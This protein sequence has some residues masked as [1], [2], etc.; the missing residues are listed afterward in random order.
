VCRSK[1]VHSQTTTVRLLSFV[2]HS[3]SWLTVVKVRLVVK[4]SLTHC[5]L[6]DSGQG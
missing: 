3:A 6:A 5:Q 4:V 1:V 2:T